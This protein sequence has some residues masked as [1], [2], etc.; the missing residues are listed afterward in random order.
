MGNKKKKLVGFENFQG[1][2]ETS[3][4]EI[5]KA[6][7]L[8]KQRYFT[9]A[10]EFIKLLKPK[11]FM[12]FAGL[13][14]LTGSLHTLNNKRGIPELEE[15]YNYLTSKFDQNNH[16]GVILNADASFNITT[17]KAD[18][19]YK[20]I[21][22]IAKQEYIK[23]VLSK[24]KFDFEEEF[25]PTADYLMQYIPKAYQRFNSKLNELHYSSDWTILLDVSQEEMV[26]ISCN[27]GGFKRISNEEGKK[28]RKFLRFSV[29]PRLL[30]WLLQG[31]KKAHWNNA[32]IGSHIQFKR[33]PNVYDR[34]IHYCFNWFY[35]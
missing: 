20:L 18:K 8:K 22:P 27:G 7:K 3:E 16:K 30:N 1:F 10:E 14:T 6:K 35:S 12:P 13:Y 15:G 26:A 31:P 29:D 17:G 21:D 9:Q 34:A 24:Y 25:I 28:F 4:E 2:R 5:E 19:E 11:F 32:E 23:N 33:F